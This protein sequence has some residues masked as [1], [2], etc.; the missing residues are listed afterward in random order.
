MERNEFVLAALSSCPDA[1]YTPVQVQ[2]L[3]FLIDEKIPALVE[4]PH[5]DFAPYDYGP[6]DKR[7]YWTLETL[8][9]EGSV[10]IEGSA[11][12]RTYTTTKSGQKKGEI[13][14]E[15]LPTKAQAYIKELVNFVRYLSFNELVSAI[16][17]AYPEMRANSVFRD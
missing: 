4:G 5:F 3:F 7:V 14:F 1:V 2:K 15:E 16:Y 8:A 17:K 10:A 13:L 11:S 6:F 12:Y 9:D